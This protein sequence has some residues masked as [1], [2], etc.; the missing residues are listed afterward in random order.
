MTDRQRVTEDRFKTAL[1]I[2]AQTHSRIVDQS[3]FG[4][5]GI[6]CTIW[7][8][9]RQRRRCP[10]AVL[11]IRDRSLLMN[12]FVVSFE[13]VKPSSA[14]CGNRESSSFIRHARAAARND[15]TKR[16]PIVV[17]AHIE[18][19]VR[20]ASSVPQRNLRAVTMIGRG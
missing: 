17:D 18:H 4:D 1:A 5:R 6:A 19:I 2:G 11:N 14:A 10:F 3:A 7:Q 13:I 15:V 12:A 20:F 16:Y 8:L 9:D